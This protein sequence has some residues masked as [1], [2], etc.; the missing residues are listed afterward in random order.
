VSGGG[1]RNVKN[2]VFAVDWR[3]EGIG[4]PVGAVHAVDFQRVEVPGKYENACLGF[5]PT[6]KIFA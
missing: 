3:R 5:I 1:G 2:E 6:Y 4:P